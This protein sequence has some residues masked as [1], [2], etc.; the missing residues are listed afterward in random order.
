MSKYTKLQVKVGY[1]ARGDKTVNTTK[2]EI[3]YFFSQ[4]QTKFQKIKP[5]KDGNTPN[6]TLNNT[7]INSSFSMPMQKRQYG[8]GTNTSSKIQTHRP[9]NS[10]NYSKQS[11]SLNQTLKKNYKDLTKLLSTSQREHMP[12]IKKSSMKLKYQQQIFD[13][14]HLPEK[15][16]KCMSA[17]PITG[18][19]KAH[20]TLDIIKTP[21]KRPNKRTNSTIT[22]NND[23]D[24]TISSESNNVINKTKGKA[25]GKGLLRRH[26]VEI[27]KEIK[28]RKMIKGIH[29]KS[30]T[31]LNGDEKK[32]NQD[33]S[34]IFNNFN[35][36]REY[37]F[38]GV[39]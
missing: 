25:I 19:R 4:Q 7:T 17:K 6:I 15:K 24:T 30:N 18:L 27:K 29:D 26:S 32:I 31:G 11:I 39:W 14:H 10:V 38:M 23:K 3:N 9:T 33:S 21:I 16:S 37:I 28:I 34:F 20:N 5:A 1:T 2:K 35:G 22:N 13:Y 36:H 8:K 12:F